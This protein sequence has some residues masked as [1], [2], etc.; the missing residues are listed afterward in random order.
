[1]VR[2]S[3]DASRLATGGSDGV[4]RIWSFPAMTLQVEL[5]GLNAQVGVKHD[6][7]RCTQRLLILV[8]FRRARSLTLTLTR[9]ARAL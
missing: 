6:P 8:S 3:S 9:R 4:V 7:C 2:F 1:M 5:K